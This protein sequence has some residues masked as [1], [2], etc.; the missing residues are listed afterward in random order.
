MAFFGDSLYS[1]MPR[2]GEA[3]SSC[4]W[5]SCSFK[6]W[7]SVDRCMLGTFL[8]IRWTKWQDSNCDRGRCM[9]SIGGAPHVCTRRSVCFHKL[10]CVFAFSHIVLN[11]HP[12]IQLHQF[13]FLP[14]VQ[15]AILSLEMMYKHRLEFR[16]QQARLLSLH[17]CYIDGGKLGRLALVLKKM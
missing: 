1:E 15:L 3:S 14:F 7:R 11:S 6:W 16:F 13:W 8:S 2:S 12:G 10:Y 17:N 4:P 9:P 5:A